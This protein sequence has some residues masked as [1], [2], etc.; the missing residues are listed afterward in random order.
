[1]TR[2]EALDKAAEM[3]DKAETSLNDTHLQKHLSIAQLYMTL[4][5]ITND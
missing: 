4:A 1:M 2:Q 5:N 3:L